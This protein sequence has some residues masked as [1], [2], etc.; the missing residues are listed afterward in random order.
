MNFPAFTG[1]VARALRVSE[2]RLNELLRR[3]KIDP[4]PLVEHGRR[5][6]LAEHVRQTARFLGKPDPFATAEAP[7]GA[8]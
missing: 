6:W 4:A 7:E 1:T 5:L 2:P 3:G 8:K